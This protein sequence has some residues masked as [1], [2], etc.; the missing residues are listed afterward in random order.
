MLP[1]DLNV[2]LLAEEQSLQASIVAPLLYAQLSC[3][4]IKGLSRLA[5]CFKGDLIVSSS[6]PLA[7]TELSIYPV[8]VT[9]LL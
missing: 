8:L 5:H 6:W 4:G 7:S 3:A 9:P 2:T 1:V